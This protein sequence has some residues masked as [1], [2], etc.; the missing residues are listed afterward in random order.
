MLLIGWNLEKRII[1]GM[2]KPSR[3]QF[4]LMRCK[5]GCNKEFLFFSNKGS[6]PDYINSKHKRHAE[7]S[8]K[9][10]WCGKHSVKK[11]PT[12]K[13]CS[14]LC[15]NLSNYFGSTKE[16]EA[17]AQSLISMLWVDGASRKKLT[18]TFGQSRA[19]K[20]VDYIYGPDAW[21]MLNRFGLINTP[22]P[23]MRRSKYHVGIKKQAETKHS[24]A[25][26]VIARIIKLW[27]S[28][29][30]IKQ[31][32]KMFGRSESWVH[33]RAIYCRGYKKKSRQRI[34]ESK[35]RSMEQR[36]RCQS[37]KYKNEKTFSDCVYNQV[38]DNFDVVK[39][40]E[41]AS[42]HGDMRR[43][44]LF[45]MDGLFRYAIE[46]KNTNRSARS[47]QCFGQALV[48]AV[49]MNA[50]PVCVWPDDVRIDI[51]IKQAAK[52]Y[53]CIVCNESEL[54]CSIKKA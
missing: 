7:K 29:N 11:S 51:V 3:L 45:V 15:S 28:G 17:K 13:H 1:K 48:K 50:I 43:V 21:E 46:L 19:R 23:H 49:Q 39:R 20:L 5:C 34:A 44:D 8:I 37:A 36:S 16:R 54:I 22:Q 30:H 25:R 4:S 47:D 10:K 2:K 38:K 14:C 12:A 33:S 27:R 53:G 6:N 42:N 31:I 35:W 32:A 41:P 52:H 24:D 26:K 40:E 9:C 18:E